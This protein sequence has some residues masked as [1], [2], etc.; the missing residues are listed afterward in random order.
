MDVRSQRSCRH[1]GV[2]LG[3]GLGAASFDSTSR[4]LASFDKLAVRTVGG[5]NVPPQVALGA[6]VPNVPVTVG[7]SLLLQAFAT[8]VDGSIAG[9]DFRINGQV[10]ATDTTPPY[11]LTWTAPAAGTY[12][13]T[14][15][16]R[17]DAGAPATS[18]QQMVSVQAAAPPSG[19]RYRLAFQ[20]S[21]HATL[22]TNYLIEVFRAGANPA[23]APPLAQLFAGRPPLTGSEV[24][25]DVTGMVAQLSPGNYIF[26]ATAQGPGGS[27]RSASTPV[28]R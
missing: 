4:V 5:A 26:T 17:D 18:A 13:V 1:A 23:T 15:V 9:V 20:S 11:T 27:A 16:A 12:S 6:P 25:V 21:D 24:I 22:V 2:D 8:D 19:L 3:L 14:A 10:V 7:R 28:T